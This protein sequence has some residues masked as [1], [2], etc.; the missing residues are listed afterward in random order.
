VKPPTELV[1][2]DASSNS[3]PP[4]P[5]P[6]SCPFTHFHGYA[7]RTELLHPFGC[8]VVAHLQEKDLPDPKLP[9]RG[10]SGVYLGNSAKR[11]GYKILDPTTHKIIKTR[12]V[13][14]YPTNF[15]MAKERN[16][17]VKTKM[18]TATPYPEEFLDE[19]ENDYEYFSE[20]DSD[21]EAVALPT[22]KSQQHKYLPQDQDEVPSSSSFEPQPD[23][24]H[25]LTEISTPTT[26]ADTTVLLTPSGDVSVGQEGEQ[27]STTL[28]L[29]PSQ[30]NQSD[31]QLQSEKIQASTEAESE[32]AQPPPSRNLQLQLTTRRYPRRERKR[33][34]ECWKAQTSNKQANSTKNKI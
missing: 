11:K 20:T 18:E 25:P 29:E 10:L 16:R 33:P 15:E 31:A 21:D 24:N 12:N 27:G 5:T 1:Q 3:V 32:N 30:Q 7:P 19:H 4:T 26:L 6:P 28:P 2:N 14:F 8:K 34:Q 22:H 23:F 13:T 17:I 9:L